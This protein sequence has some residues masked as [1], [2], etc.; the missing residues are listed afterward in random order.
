M[1]VSVE[2][3]GPGLFLDEWD[4]LA[5]TSPSGVFGTAEWHAAVQKAYGDRGRAAVAA[6]REHDR[7]LGVAPFR[8]GSRPLIH[9]ATLLGMGEGGYGLGDYAGI[10][11]APGREGD[12]ADAVVSWLAASAGWDLLDLQ[13]LPPGRLTKALLESI[14]RAG[15]RSLVRRH[16]I[17]HVI[18]LPS[19]WAEYRSR[20]SPG[21]R[22]WL[23]RKPRKA[24]RE[25]GATIELIEPDRLIEEYRTMRRFQAQRFGG[26][27]PER[28]SKLAAVI[29]A[30]LPVAYERNW[31]RMFRL[32][33]GS[34]T[35]GVLLG[36]EY[37]DAFYFHSAAFES[38]GEGAKYSLGASLLAAALHY[39]IDHGLERFDM[40][41]G[42]YDYK[43]RL[44]SEKRY[45][46]R[47]MVF[48]DS[49]MGR[50]IEAALHIRTILKGKR[51]WRTELEG[52]LDV[53]AGSDD[54]DRSARAPEHLATSP[55]GVE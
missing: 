53:E 27:P 6:F 24:E 5:R 29:S 1:D 9:D 16:N 11:A 12:V 45:N 18:E 33:S 54:S 52:P 20:L 30:W 15:L 23:E 49:L 3:P 34:R 14:R 10:L 44:G 28:E 36:Y 4:A 35:I 40:L 38:L 41:R 2:T 55:V 25:L 48:R 43:V 51:P 47:V 19:T 26:Q 21:A 37:E 39:S 50:G 31:L 32:R 22:D 46:Y 8:F 7:L 17:C 42:H 13:Q